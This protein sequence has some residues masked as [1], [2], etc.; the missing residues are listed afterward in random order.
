MDPH[1]VKDAE[2]R[3]LNIYHINVNLREGDEKLKVQVLGA[4]EISLALSDSV[5]GLNR[6][7]LLQPTCCTSTTLRGSWRRCRF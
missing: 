6:L 4:L 5:F 3:L 7:L 1:I 2:N